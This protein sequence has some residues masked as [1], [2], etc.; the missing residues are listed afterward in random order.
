MI[1]VNLNLSTTVKTCF[2]GAHPL[3][4]DTFCGP[5][6]VRT[7]YQSMAQNLSDM[8]RSTFVI[9]GI[10]TLFTWSG[11]PRSSGVGFLCFVYTRAWK[12]KKPTPL[13]RHRGP[14]LHVNRPLITEIAPVW[15]KLSGIVWTQSEFNIFIVSISRRNYRLWSLFHW[16]K[17]SSELLN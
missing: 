9:A 3:N 13:D 7:Q 1:N 5:L 6:S 11:G 12:Q 16:H 8:W 4:T 2:L 17:L 15:F 10:K 14:P